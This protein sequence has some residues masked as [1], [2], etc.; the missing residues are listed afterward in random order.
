MQSPSK[1]NRSLNNH[2]NVIEALVFLI[3]SLAISYLAYQQKISLQP[4]HFV[5]L[6]GALALILGGL[7]FIRSLFAQLQ[8]LHS[9]L[10]TP[11]PAASNPDQ[12]TPQLTQQ[13]PQHDYADLSS[14]FKLMLTQYQQKEAELE[15]AMKR[16]ESA[17]I[18]KTRFLATM[19]HELLTPLGIV[20]G[21]ADVL[22]NQTHGALSADQMRFA[23]HIFDNG[24]QLNNLV[25]DIL[26]TVRLESD[27]F[28]LDLQISNPSL[29]IARA[30]E[31][32][33]ATAEAKRIRIEANLPDNLPAFH[34]DPSLVEKLLNKLLGNAIKFSPENGTIQVN[35]SFLSQQHL[36]EVIPEAKAN[37]GNT[38][39]Q[40][41]NARSY[42]QIEITDEG[43]GYEESAHDKL[44][45]MFEQGNN[46]R[47][48]PQGGSG[49]G[50]AI[51]QQIARLH[52]GY[53][54]SQSNGAGNGASFFVALPTKP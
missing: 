4:S 26:T 2:L 46:S 39:P 16:A 28:K 41:N 20:M 47:E 40:P 38:D 19:G 18:A 22:R 30:I 5:I 21:F 14:A 11:R 12:L 51:S 8:S 52:G 15:A 23:N 45:A 31:A 50:L 37:H 35:A 17:N 13:A 44:F 24:K 42:L 1:H 29:E 49:I 53:L 9:M 36:L 32:S 7:L 6:A 3:P 10:E 34:A 33:S 48:R 25:Q 54:W 43:V 27:E